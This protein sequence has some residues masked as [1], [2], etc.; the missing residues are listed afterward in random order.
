MRK[1]DNFLKG[2]VECMQRYTIYIDN[3]P[4][5]EYLTILS[6]IASY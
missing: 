2:R 4:L 1:E 5:H 3:L 6:D